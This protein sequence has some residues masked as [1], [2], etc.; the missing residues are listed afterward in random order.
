M[1]EKLYICPYNT[2]GAASVLKTYII[3]TT[4][5]QKSIRNKIE[6]PVIFVTYKIAQVSTF[7]TYNPV[8]QFKYIYYANGVDANNVD[9][10][11]TAHNEPSHQDLHYLPVC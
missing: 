1:K 10:D 8:D 3:A 2:F 9:P 4:K 6:A 7:N 5:Q 11:E